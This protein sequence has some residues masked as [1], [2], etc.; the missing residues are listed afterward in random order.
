MIKLKIAGAS[1]NDCFGYNIKQRTI[2]DKTP[3]IP[4]IPIKTKVMGFKFIK[5]P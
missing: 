3:G 1:K 5:K 2:R 4:K